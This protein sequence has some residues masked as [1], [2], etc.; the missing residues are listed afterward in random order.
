MLPGRGPVRVELRL[1]RVGLFGWDLSSLGDSDAD[2]GGHSDANLFPGHGAVSAERPVLFS[3]LYGG[4]VPVRG[5]RSLAKL[6]ALLALPL[7]LA[8]CPQAQVDRWCAVR[9]K[10]HSFVFGPQPIE[11]GALAVLD[12]IIAIAPVPPKWAALYVPAKLAL[13]SA[14]AQLADLC[15]RHDRGERVDVATAAGLVAQNAILLQQ[16]LQ[17]Y[18]EAMAVAP[19]DLGIVET[20]PVPEGL[21]VDLARVMVEATRAR[22][23]ER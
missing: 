14:D 15:L 17:T 7:A 16:V 13:V 4:G 21:E 2:P 11:G 3:E 23:R 18:R 19:R 20:P 1:L 22:E 9:A 8:G 5:L 6:A 10:A 12:G